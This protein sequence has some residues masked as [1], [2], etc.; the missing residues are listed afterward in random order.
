MPHLASCLQPEW[1]HG[2]LNRIVSAQTHPRQEVLGNRAE[3][4]GCGT[5]GDAGE[6][7][8]T[9]TGGAAGSPAGRGPTA[10]LR[11]CRSA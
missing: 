4:G 10:H 2:Q 8:G 5:R 11:L 1:W 7:E 9:A 6:P 3:A